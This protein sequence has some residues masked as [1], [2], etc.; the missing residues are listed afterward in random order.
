MADDFNSKTVPCSFELDGASDRVSFAVLAIGETGSNRLPERMRV[1][2]PGSRVDGTGNNSDRW[3]TTAV[4]FNGMR[5]PGVP[6]DP[7]PTELNKLKA[8]LKRSAK[9]T[10]TLTLST[11]GPKRC[12]AAEWHEDRTFERRDYCALQI[13]WLEDNEETQLESTFTAP[14]ARSAAEAL[15]TEIVEG[16]A[17]L[18]VWSPDI[19]ELESIAARLEQLAVKASEYSNDL[20]QAARDVTASVGRIEEG[21]LPSS[22]LLQAGDVMVGETPQTLLSDPAAY[23]TLVALRKLAEMA[24]QAMA[25]VPG[26][27]RPR[28]I[29]YGYTV[30]IM[31]VATEHGV[32]IDKL[33]ELN[34]SIAEPLMILANIPIYLPAA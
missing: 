4:F 32:P 33:V 24:S 34:T 10:G 18:G 14:N 3:T 9:K 29:T 7:Y 11:V 23:Q 13:T 22:T 15:A 16:C 25:L 2:R 31:D 28:F 27:S 8:L 5:E 17:Y 12:K 26:R 30:S 1:Y 21:F 19:A 6:A 20:E